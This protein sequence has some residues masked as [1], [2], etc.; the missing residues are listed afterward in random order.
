MKTF[1]LAVI[2]AGVGI[3]AAPQISAL[4][5]Q[6]Q[7]QMLAE[8]YMKS[9]ESECRN[10]TTKQAHDMCIWATSSAHALADETIGKIK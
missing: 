6:Q 1:L 4:W 7:A 2:A 3:I 5:E 10:E 9:A 8:K